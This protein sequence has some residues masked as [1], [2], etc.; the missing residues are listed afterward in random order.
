MFQRNETHHQKS[1][2]DGSEHLAARL[3]EQLHDSWAETFYHE[4][5][6]RI[7]ETIFE[8][9]YS[10]EASRPNAPANVL[11]G[12]EVLKSGFGWSD[13]HLE[14]QAQFN[15]QIR[16]ALGMRD[17]K[18]APPRRRTLYNFRR[19]VREHAEET[20]MNLYAEVFAQV[21]DEQLEA[22]GLEAE[23]QRMDSTQVLSNL[24]ETSR[25]ELVISVVRKIHGL[26]DE[27]LRL[28]F[29]E[30]LESYVE[31]RP[32]EVA[33]RI[34]A[35]ESGTHLEVLGELLM[36]L[37]AALSETDPDGGA[38]QLAER[39]LRE[40]YEVSPEGRVSLRAPGEISA[41]S[42]QSPH[43]PE[44]TFRVK[45][46][47]S[48][49]GGYVVNVSETCG[50]GNCAQVITDVQV[51]PNCTDDAELLEHSLEEQEDRVSAPERVT[52]D[53]GYTG[54]RA[55]KSCEEREVELRATRMRGRPSGPNRLGPEDYEWELDEDGDPV[56]VTCPRGERAEVEPTGAQGR[57]LA[58]FPRSACESCPLFGACQVQERKTLG[59]TY[60]ITKRAAHVARQRKRLCTEDK[61]VRAAGEATMRSI[62]H[63]FGGRKLPVRGE[64]RCAMLLYP[65]AL[66][67]NLRRLHR[68]GAA[69]G[70]QNRDK[71]AERQ[72][73]PILLLILGILATLSSRPKKCIRARS[74]QP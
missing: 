20:G 74:L 58:R 73:I 72:G 40:Q 1:F 42:L 4:V 41:S 52:T 5:F 61:G 35:A 48:Y 30:R 9:L 3:R 37:A 17:L 24:A 71:S 36:E 45:A 32:H 19:R 47:K 59:P 64:I 27:E 62:K 10:E 65:G 16:H 7:D 34:P 63:P 2:F 67:V 12:M 68:A 50:P 70:A 33:Y 49:S 43:D 69:A 39:V 55:E 21:T 57:F 44:A 18:D 23:W 26:M 31:K 38:A 15:L 29:S 25:L 53:G 66:M 22:V 11:M 14:Q 28:R 56:A 51:A 8:D 46:G 54:K 6:C 60:Y 13:R